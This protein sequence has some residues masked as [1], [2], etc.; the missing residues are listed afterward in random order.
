MTFPSRPVS[1]LAAVAAVVVLGSG[2]AGAQ[3]WRGGFGFYA[4]PKFPTANSFVGTFNFCRLMF[5]SNRREKRGWSTD[6][7]GADINFSVRLAELT[8]TRVTKGSSGDPEY[9]VVRPTDP[10]LMQCPFILV[11]DGGTAVFNDEEIL[12]LRE[13][14]QKGGFLF[15]SDYWGTLAAAQWDEAIGRVLPP[16][17]Y[18]IVDIAM[19]HPMWQTLFD[20]KQVPQ[21][22]SIQFWRRSGGGMSERGADS[23]HVDVRGIADR[24]GRFMVV[25]LHNTDIPDGWER[26]AED[27]DYFNRFSPDAYS[28]AINVLMYAMTH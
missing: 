11:E 26:E 16:A 7:P 20:V 15:V 13:Y 3:I 12:R 19:D 2:A 1:W 22:A 14:L 5:N 6:Y 17:E 9:V 25:M 28:V 24:R 4:S 18:P 10:A 23:A 21:M 27:P 8:K